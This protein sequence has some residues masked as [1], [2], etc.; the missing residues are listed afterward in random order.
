VLL[1]L[2][3]DMYVLKGTAKITR[4]RLKEANERI[5]TLILRTNQLEVIIEQLR[6]GQ[7]VGKDLNALARLG[8]PPPARQIG[9]KRPREQEL[10][11]LGIRPEVSK[12]K[13]VGKSLGV[14]E[15][16]VPS[17]PKK[18]KRGRKD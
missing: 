8:R 14:A 11:Q 17:A 15:A 16:D 1:Q 6:G 5:E 18:V 2:R 3:R 12:G 7:R 9:A 4:T 10:K 13:K